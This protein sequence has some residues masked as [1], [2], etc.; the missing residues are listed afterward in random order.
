MAVKISILSISLIFLSLLHFH[1]NNVRSF[2]MV[3]PSSSHQPV[4]INAKLVMEGKFDFR[5]F[6]KPHI[7]HRQHH[8]EISSDEGAAKTEINPH[9]VTGDRLVPTG[10]NPLHN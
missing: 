10:P 2:F 6:Q 3:Y 5:P 7:L 8:G 9:Y 4:S 1:L